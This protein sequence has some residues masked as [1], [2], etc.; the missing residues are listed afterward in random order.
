MKN[1]NNKTAQ[2]HTWRFF[3]TGGF[4]QVRIDTAEDLLNIDKLDQ[5]LW[6]ALAC[7][8]DNVY[9]DT[10]TL[11]LIDSDGDK[12]IR[13]NE[14]VDAIK[15][16]G[17]ILKNPDEM[18]K[19]NDHISIEDIKDLTEEG[20]KL[21]EMV[22]S[23]LKILGKEE[24]GSI[25][26][27]E[28]ND[29]EK[30]FS[31]KTFN[32]DG[33]IT[34]DTTSD[35]FLKL[36]IEEIVKVCGHVV[37][38]SGKQG[39]DSNLVEDFFCKAME[40]LAWE[41]MFKNDQKMQPLQEKTEEALKIFLSVKNKIE[42]YY[43]RCSIAEFDESSVVSLNGGENALSS[44]ILQILSVDC[45]Q[46]KN[47]P[48][49]LVKP[50]QPLPL[51]EGINPAWQN[52]ISE[53][54]EKIVRPLFGE[55]IV[56]TFQ[57]WK[58]LCVIFAPALSHYEN[59]PALIADKIEIDRIKEITDSSAKKDILA[60]IEQDRFESVTFDSIALINKLIL[61]KRDL[62]PLCKN[63]I[64]FKDFYS[65]DPAAI[66][67]A[68]KLYI[69]QR[70]C[71]LCIKIDDHAKHSLMAA[72]AGT[73]LVYCE[74]KRKGEPKSITIVAAFTNGD[75]ENLMVGR[76]GIFYDRN[77]KDWDAVIIKIINNPIS[78]S[79]AFW[80]PYKSFVRMIESQVAKRAVD[81]ETQSTSKLSQTA[82]STVNIDKTKSETPSVPKKIDVGIIAA[83]GVAAGALGTFVATLLGYMSGIIRLGPLAII[84]ALL[85]LIA[86]I[87]GPSLILAY[88]K[89]RKRNLGPILDAGGWAINARAKI[90]VP[91]GTLLTH[92]ATLP[93]GS[94]RDLIDPYAEK[95]SPWPKI[96][97]TIVAIYLAYSLFDHLGYIEKWSNSLGG[98]KKEMIIKIVK[99]KKD[100]GLK[101]VEFKN[102][103]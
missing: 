103:Q 72:M 46:L 43:T 5:K 91:F 73:Y 42:D 36:V 75:S 52:K 95:K 93:A 21:R 15:W 32:G 66:F 4:D 85:G 49:A 60:L 37:D 40:F 74:C 26:I 8:I 16:T 35:Y 98:F 11:K 27:K 47:L 81:A 6:A 1:K 96:I 48:V 18:L 9:F 14:L 65:K 64:N 50:R 101:P 31:S 10:T 77:G 62:Y 87:S 76:N 25:S 69:D 30:S 80:L 54:K 20:R 67:Q 33:I 100:A 55:K 12:R 94:Q 19:C 3:K 17:N 28:L 61:F 88:I 38:R 57:E 2:L 82:A 24:S 22:R 51:T 71:N 97:I 59:R 90:S 92:T 44:C 29:L 58:Q 68:G 13:A 23:S 53:F 99:D 89:L 79:E 7:P 34:V 70:S 45:E 102:E 56:L 41:H 83:L 84:G 63:F 78:L 39:I 86:L